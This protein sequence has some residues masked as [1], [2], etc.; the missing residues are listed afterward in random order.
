[1]AMQIVKCLSNSEE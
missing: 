1:M